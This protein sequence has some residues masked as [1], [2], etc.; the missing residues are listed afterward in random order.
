MQYLKFWRQKDYFILFG[1]TTKKNSTLKPQFS[2]GI[3]GQSRPLSQYSGLLEF[4][5]S[6]EFSQWGQYWLGRIFHQSGPHKITLASG[7]RPRDRTLYAGLLKRQSTISAKSTTI[8]NI[9][10]KSDIN[11]VNDATQKYYFQKKVT[12]NVT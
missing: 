3:S 5:A 12:T 11:N 8:K 6:F 9:G 2:Y 1:T 10:S 7:R 4:D